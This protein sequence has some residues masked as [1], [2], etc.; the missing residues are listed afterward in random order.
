MHTQVLVVGYVPCEGSEPRLV[1]RKPTTHSPTA[2]GVLSVSNDLGSH[3]GMSS[4]GGGQSSASVSAYSD[5]TGGV[6]CV[7]VSVCVCVKP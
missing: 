4:V 7:C 6:L 3:G 5:E 1:V 2:N